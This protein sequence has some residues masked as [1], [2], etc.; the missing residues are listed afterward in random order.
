[1]SCVQ[2]NVDNID[3]D[4]FG[5]PVRGAMYQPAD[6]MHDKLKKAT[7][8]IVREAYKENLVCL[9]VFRAGISAFPGIAMTLE[10]TCSTTN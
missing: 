2:V 6:E 5:R 1:M 3:A 4:L 10:T 8:Q 7:H 9:S